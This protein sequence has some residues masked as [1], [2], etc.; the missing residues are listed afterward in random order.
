[1]ISLKKTTSEVSKYDQERI[2][3]LRLEAL[4]PHIDYTPFYYYFFKAYVKHHG[5][6]SGN[7][8]YA[9]AFADAYAAWGVSIDPGELIVGKPTREP[10]TAEEQ[11]EW[12][13]MPLACEKVAFDIASKK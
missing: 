8:R 12:E 7:H 1:M 10:L 11:A 9:M 4:Q 3:K 2:E 5:Q 6:T 13:I